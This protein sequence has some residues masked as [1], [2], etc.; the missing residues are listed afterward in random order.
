MHEAVTMQ[1]SDTPVEAFLR[2][3]L[4]QGDAVLRTVAPVLGHL[5]ATRDH[6]LF[7]DEVIARVRGMLSD[8]ARQLLAVETGGEEGPGHSQWA[9]GERPELVEALRANQRLVLHCHALALEWQLTARLEKRSASDPVLS[10]LLQA[11]IA[12]DNPATASLA[13]ALLAAQAR[14]VQHQRRMELPLLELPGYLFGDLLRS[15]SATGGAAAARVA[16]NLRQDYRESASR[17]SLIARLV[18]EMG[19]GALAALSLDH[20]GVSIFLSAL[21]ASTG[22]DRDLITISTDDRQIARLALALRAAGL[23]QREIEEQ[24][25]QIH[26]DVGLPDGF[27]ALRPDRAAALLGAAGQP[28]AV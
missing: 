27:D 1:P 17:L 7:S 20:A 18:T 22:Q 23:K 21:A 24:L 26:F 4:A 2:H 28:T 3:E 8:I 13:M 11:L 14:F 19:A 10:P 6:S 9:E 15:W 16:E 25:A 5:L 12:S